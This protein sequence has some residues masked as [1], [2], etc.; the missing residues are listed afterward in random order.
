MR[1]FKVSIKVKIALLDD[2]K[3][4]LYTIWLAQKWHKYGV[5]VVISS[6]FMSS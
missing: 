6:Y 1:L 5:I 3:V 4:I 2:F